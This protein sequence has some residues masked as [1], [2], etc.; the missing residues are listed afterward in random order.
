M[1][2]LASLQKFSFPKTRGRSWARL[3]KNGVPDAVAVPSHDFD[4]A[5]ATSL[6]LNGFLALQTS[7]SSLRGGQ[8]SYVARPWIL[9]RDTAVQNIDD[10][11][12]VFYQNPALLKKKHGFHKLVLIVDGSSVTGPGFN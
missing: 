5:K 3:D 11:L 6:V 4:S 2:R 9:Q 7:E 10:L 1:Q 8:L 12:L